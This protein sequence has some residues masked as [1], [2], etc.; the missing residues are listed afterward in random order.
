MKYSNSSKN[1]KVSKKLTSTSAG[2]KTY[3]QKMSDNNTNSSGKKNSTY[4]RE[5]SK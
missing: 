2:A 1:G 3:G 4:V 5:Q